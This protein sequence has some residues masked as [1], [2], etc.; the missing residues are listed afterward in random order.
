[1]LETISDFGKSPN[2]TVKWYFIIFFQTRA[3]KEIL[4]PVSLPV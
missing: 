4:K 2:F 1:M 3:A